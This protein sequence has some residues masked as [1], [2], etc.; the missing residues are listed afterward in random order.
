MSP[1]SALS[2]AAPTAPA[3]VPDDPEAAAR[4]FET[5]LVRQFVEVMTRDLFQGEDGGMLSGQADLQ[6]DTLTDTLAEH[7]VESGTFGI[8]DLL[9]AQWA[10]QGRVP[11]AEAADRSPDRAASRADAPQPPTA[12][13]AGRCRWTTRSDATRRLKSRRPPSIP[14]PDPP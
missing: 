11:S 14:T 7:L 9:L 10:R 4:Q 6:R 13:R 5:V 8:A 12:A 3:P 1:I 2:A